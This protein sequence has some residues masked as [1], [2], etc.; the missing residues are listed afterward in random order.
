MNKDAL[1][2]LLLVLSSIH[3]FLPFSF[4]FANLYLSSL[5][6]YIYLSMSIFFI[7][8]FSFF[9][10]LQIYVSPLCISMSFF[11]FMCLFLLS[12]NYP[13]FVCKFASL[14]SIVCCLS[15]LRVCF[16]HLYILPLSFVF[17]N[18]FLSSLCLYVYHLSYVVF[19]CLFFSSL[20]ILFASQ[21]IA[22]FF[23]NGYSFFPPSLLHWCFHFM[24]QCCNSML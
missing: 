14:F 3:S 18:L 1:V 23:Y 12:F 5:H 21:F 20:H 13:F 8:T 22:T 2:V 15:S 9:L 16:F 17:V 4:V 11:I 24:F 19:V 6:L 7:F 10:C